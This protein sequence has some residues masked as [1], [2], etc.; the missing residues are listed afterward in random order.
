MLT[1][2]GWNQRSSGLTPWWGVGGGPP[3][4]AF[5]L[6]LFSK[7]H[8]LVPSAMEPIF[9]TFSN[10]QVPWAR[11]G[12]YVAWCHC[13]LSPIGKQLRFH[14][15]G[16]TNNLSLLTFLLLIC[17]IWNIGWNVCGYYRVGGVFRWLWG[18]TSYYNLANHFLFFSTCSIMTEKVWKVIGII[19]VH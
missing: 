17:I 9:F 13:L 18:I 5:P 16:S 12:Q 3:L 4:L 11:K 1:S 14:L 7:S 10:N 6:L 2:S 19:N 15:K 8:F